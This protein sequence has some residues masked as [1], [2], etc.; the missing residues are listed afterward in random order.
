MVAVA[1]IKERCF[2]CRF[3]MD[4][5][6]INFIDFQAIINIKL[7]LGITARRSPAEVNREQLFAG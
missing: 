4:V 7:L 6:A 5:L 1:W 3:K 2:Q